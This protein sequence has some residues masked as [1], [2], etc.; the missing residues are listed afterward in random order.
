MDELHYELWM[1]Q[2][3]FS[4][5]AYVNWWNVTSKDV[6]YVSKMIP[7]F[8]ATSNPAGIGS[9]FYAIIYDPLLC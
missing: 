1:R 3:V 4:T 2:S 5:E 6:Q 9:R 8:N 7:L